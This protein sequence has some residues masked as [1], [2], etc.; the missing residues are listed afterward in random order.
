MRALTVFSA[1]ILSAVCLFSGCERSQR[2]VDERSV[3]VQSEK[4]QPLV[5]EYAKEFS[6]ERFAD[7]T[8]L[9]HIADDR[10]YALIP[11]GSTWAPP[12][13]ATVIRTP[14]DSFYLAGSATL[15]MFLR[16]DALDRV[17][18]CSAS[19]SNVANPDVKSAIRS[20]AIE[21]IGKY[22]APDYERLLTLGQPLAIEST[23]IYHTPKVREQ[24]EKL[25]I[26]VMIERANYESELLGRLEWIKLYGL[27][28]G[29]EAE[30]TAFF[31]REKAKV[32]ALAASLSDEDPATRPKVAFFYV[33]SNGYVNVRKPGDYL[34][35]TIELAGGRYAFDNLDSTS[36]DG[37]AQSTLNVDWETFYKEA[38]DADVIIY[39]GTIDASTKT[40]DDLIAKNSLFG[41]FKAVQ[42]GNVWGT[43]PRMYQESGAIADVLLEFKGAI[44]GDVA[45]ATQYLYRLE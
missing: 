45:F 4:I 20:G 21:Y 13:N 22:S 35:K 24:L 28:L 1:V 3:G 7:G 11:R 14:I 34:C 12:A 32:A 27:L 44:D 5:L 31:E 38:V 26:P 33:S 23:M 36:T 16:L 42:S 43:G 17:S 10:D 39:N 30:A 19:A 9:V 40:L 6:V 18:C 25:G 29:K 8:A 2:S 41:E 37:R 15:D